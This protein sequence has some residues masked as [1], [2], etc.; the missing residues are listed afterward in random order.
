[1]KKI[2]ITGANGFIGKNLLFALQDYKVLLFDKEYTYEYLDIVLKD[3]DFIFH[4]ASGIKEGFDTSL[5]QFIL[6]SLDKH[7][8]YPPIVYTSSIL[9]GVDTEHGRY[10]RL[11]EEL[12]KCYKGRVYLYRL[13]NVFGRWGR[14][15]YNSAVNTFLFNVYHGVDLKI[16]DPNKELMLVYVE[17]VVNEFRNLME[18][19]ISRES[20][21][22][23][24]VKPVYITTVG[25]VAYIVSQFKDLEATCRDIKA[26]TELISKLYLTYKK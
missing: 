16:N 24:T 19:S 2:L 21:E 5:T 3:V 22:Y 12:L 4:L 10:K 23:L 26:D 7:E 20:K 18:G 8:N 9:A 17:D 1:M 25:E 13:A 6:S 15:E 11:E 14:P